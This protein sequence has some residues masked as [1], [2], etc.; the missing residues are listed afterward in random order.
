MIIDTD[1]IEPIGKVLK[2]H[3][4]QGEI[5]ITLDIESDYLDYNPWIIIEMDGIHTPFKI[6]NLRSRSS[7]ASLVCLQ[8]VISVIDAKQ[9]VSKNIY[10]DSNMLRQWDKETNYNECNDGLYADA[11]LDFKIIDTKLGEV[12]TIESLELSTQNALFEVL[13]TNGKTVY[14]PITDDFINEIDET[15]RLIKMTLPEGLLGMQ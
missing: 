6:N 2:T 1:K 13:S 3:G 8:D 11:L 4:I 15:N 12:G 7:S 9:L 10:T 14:I 5:N